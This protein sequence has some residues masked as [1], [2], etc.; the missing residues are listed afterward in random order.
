MPAPN[1]TTPEAFADEP[2]VSH[3]TRFAMARPLGTPAGDDAPSPA[4]IR[5]WNLRAAQPVAGGGPDLTDWRYDHDTQIAVTRD[6]HP[7]TEVMAGDATANSV[8][9]LDGDEGPSE[10]WTYDFCPDYPGR[11]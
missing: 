2:L 4:G 1:S 5:P 9:H 7:I 11:P 6:G 8:S 3:S 10:D